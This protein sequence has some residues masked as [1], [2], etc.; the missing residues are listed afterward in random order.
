MQNGG[1][2]RK[3]HLPDWNDNDKFIKNYQQDNKDNSR[4]N[5]NNH[6][7]LKNNS[8]LD[9]KKGQLKSGHNDDKRSTGNYGSTFTDFRNMKI[10]KKNTQHSDSDEEIQIEE[11]KPKDTKYLK[12]KDSHDIVVE[13]LVGTPRPHI[14]IPH[15]EF[16][17][18]S[19]RNSTYQVN[20]NATGPGRR[21]GGQKSNQTADSDEEYPHHEGANLSE[22]KSVS[23][24][25][26]PAKQ[27]ELSKIRS[28]MRVKRREG[29]APSKTLEER[30][31]AKVSNFICPS[32]LT[33]R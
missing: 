20:F 14:D 23:K 11:Q 18:M 10:S 31:A 2:E 19:G 22:K 1:V 29:S 3:K 13:S 4:V 33:L 26:T 24:F 6:K 12:K 16:N 21:S 32:L 8:N 27:E 5:E 15:K 7:V 28:K 30:L 25:M 9:N 17:P